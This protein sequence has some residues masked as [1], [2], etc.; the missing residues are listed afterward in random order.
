MM[1]MNYLKALI[2]G[3]IICAIGQIILDKTKITP[4]RLLTGFV[5]SGVFLSLTGLYGK[6]VEF[7]G[8][9]A[10]VPLTG[11]GYALYNGVKKG[12]KEDGFT[13]I[14]T[15]G[16]TAAAGGIASVILF[17]VAAAL[18]SRPKSK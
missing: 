8:A 3:G 15:G 16:L 7:A 14:F 18:L 13:G 10:T 5:C 17:A 9:G 4:A 6:I 2:V 12:V 11:F 1:I